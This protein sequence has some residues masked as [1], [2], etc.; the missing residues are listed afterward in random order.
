MSIKY[1]KHSVSAEICSILRSLQRHSGHSCGKERCSAAVCVAVNLKKRLTGDHHCI[2]QELQCCLLFYCS[3][4]YFI[5][6]F[7]THTA[8]FFAQSTPEQPP[9]EPAVSINVFNMSKSLALMLLPKLMTADEAAL[10]TAKLQENGKH[11]VLQH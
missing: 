4:Y 9:V 8:Y 2:V 10:S 5:L 3:Y 11:L 7:A 6:S 1:T